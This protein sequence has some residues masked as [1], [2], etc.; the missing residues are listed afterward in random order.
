MPA[1]IHWETEM[2]KAL[3]RAKREGKHVL[4]DFFNPG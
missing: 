2:E 1:T 4:A 3:A